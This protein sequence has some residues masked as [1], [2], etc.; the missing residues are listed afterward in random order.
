MDEEVG[1]A[2]EE[3]QK[4][5]KNMLWKVLK[6]NEMIRIREKERRERKTVDR[7]RV[8]ESHSK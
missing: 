1:E 6:K 8:T 3:L 2:R 5:E 7:V 4:E